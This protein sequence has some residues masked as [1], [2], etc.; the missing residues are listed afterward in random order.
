MLSDPASTT[1]HQTSL[2]LCSGSGSSPPLGQETGL[3]LLAA[4]IVPP[5][6]RR[7]VDPSRE[8]EA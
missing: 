7:G 1:G 4:L 5:S 2:A 8:H 6:L 3:A